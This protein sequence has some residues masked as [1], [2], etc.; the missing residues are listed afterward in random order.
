MTDNPPALEQIPAR[1]QISVEDVDPTPQ[2]EQYDKIP[3]E[4]R[5]VAP[6]TRPD[7]D[8]PERDPL[9][10]AV[11]EPVT[12]RQQARDRAWEPVDLVLSW[13]TYLLEKDPSNVKTRSAVGLV[14]TTS[15]DATAQIGAVMEVLLS[16]MEYSRYKLEL[17][18]WARDADNDTEEGLRR[19]AA[20]V[21]KLVSGE[22]DPFG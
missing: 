16:P 6:K 13:G 7:D 12:P 2:D 9:P 11:N 5:N 10:V 21:K 19:L 1:R 17:R 15:D 3:E 18:R 14:L 4:L 20:T 8:A 22:L